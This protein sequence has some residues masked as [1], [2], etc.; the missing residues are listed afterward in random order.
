M[1]QQSKLRAAIGA[2][3]YMYLLQEAAAARQ[4]QEVVQEKPMSFVRLKQ[5]PGL[6]PGPAAEQQASSGAGAGTVSPWVLSGRQAVMDRRNQMQLK[7]F[8]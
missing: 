5:E 2:G 4:E 3:I 7:V 8:R 1:E 6:P